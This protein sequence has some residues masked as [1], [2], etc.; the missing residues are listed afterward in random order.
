M[1]YLPSTDRENRNIDDNAVRITTKE[2]QGRLKVKRTDTA[3]AGV[4]AEEDHAEVGEHAAHDDQ[5]VQ[6][7]R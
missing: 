5:V 7:G 3:E 1:N 6:V 4:E 2:R